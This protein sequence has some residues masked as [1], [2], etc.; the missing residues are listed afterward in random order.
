MTQQPDRSDRARLESK[1]KPLR[2]PTTPE[3]RRRFERRLDARLATL[4]RSADCTP[5]QCIGLA[6]WL[7]SQGWKAFEIELPDCEENPTGAEFARNL[8][9][10]AAQYDR[11]GRRRRYLMR[12]KELAGAAI[13]LAQRLG[14][15]DPKK[16]EAGAR[17]LATWDQYARRKRDPAY[18][19]LL[20]AVWVETAPGRWPELPP[21]LRALYEEPSISAPRDVVRRAARLQLKQEL[22]ASAARLQSS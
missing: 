6:L 9:L 2:L 18:Q 11:Q 7:R 21:E 12:S 22:E 1:S 17:E 19:K 10:E 5:E 8:L 15:R 20:D 3:E 16:G 13:D 4:A 14:I